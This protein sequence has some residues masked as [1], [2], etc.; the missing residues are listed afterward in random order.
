MV[1]LFLLLY[2]SSYLD[3][4]GMYKG[5]RGW[6]Y[7]ATSQNH[8]SSTL[9]GQWA[10]PQFQWVVQWNCSPVG[11]VVAWEVMARRSDL[12]S[13]RSDLPLGRCSQHFHLYSGPQSEKVA[14]SQYTETF[15]RHSS[16]PKLCST[17]LANA[18]LCCSF[19]ELKRWNYVLDEHVS[20]I[21]K[22]LY[23]NNF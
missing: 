14:S 1:V 2:T 10:Y 11:I 23:I 18:L 7:R 19:R 5:Q 20:I 4:K 15:S 6:W 8:S 16:H 17:F 3:K 21:H 12:Q 22:I 9:A 13:R